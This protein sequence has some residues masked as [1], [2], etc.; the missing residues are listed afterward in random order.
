MATDR[1][2]QDELLLNALVDG[3]LSPRERAAAASRLASDREFARAYAVL[4]R[5]KAS[6]VEGAEEAGTVAVRLPR[7]RDRRIAVAA[8]VAAVLV[9]LIAGGAMDWLVEREAPQAEIATQ[10]VKLVSFTQPA[11]LPDLVPA[12]LKLTATATQRGTNGEVL[13]ATYLG[14]RGCRLELRVQRAEGAVVTADGTDR[15][16]WQVGDLVYQLVAYGMPAERFIAVAEAA[17]RATRAGGSPV[18]PGRRLREARISAPPC[19]A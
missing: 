7:Q 4:M 6:V 18:A 3:E 11:V 15:R 5:L 9:A 12:G 13:I 14:P 1:A 19:L 8:G 16:N 10:T 17:E 2:S